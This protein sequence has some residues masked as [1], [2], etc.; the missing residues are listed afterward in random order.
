MDWSLRKRSAFFIGAFV[1]IAA[2]ILSSG[3]K[4]NLRLPTGTSRPAVA[5]GDSH[6]VILASDGSL[7]VWG[8]EDSGWPVLGLGSVHQQPRLRRLGTNTD[9]VD[10]AAGGSH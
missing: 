8:Q 7:W 10:V 3:S 4:S 6:G 1:L 2:W 9:W 5:L